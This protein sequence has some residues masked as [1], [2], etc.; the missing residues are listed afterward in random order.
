MYSWYARH[1]TVCCIFAGIFALVPLL[2]ALC[3]GSLSV[4]FMI[5][6]SAYGGPIAYL[7]WEKTKPTEPLKPS[8]PIRKFD[9]EK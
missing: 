7:L 2:M 9:H 3:A 6:L 1:S 4:F 8:L 5:F